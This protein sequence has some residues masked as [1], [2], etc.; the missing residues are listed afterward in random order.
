MEAA[1]RSCRVYSLRLRM[2]SGVRKDKVSE[3]KGV[4]E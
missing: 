2:Q 1:N 4:T 3:Q